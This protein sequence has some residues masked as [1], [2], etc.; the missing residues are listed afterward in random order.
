MTLTITGGDQ[1]YTLASEGMP[2]GSAAAVAGSTI[3]VT[4]TTPP[5]A[6]TKVVLKVSGGGKAG[7]RTV[8][9]KTT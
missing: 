3:T 7:R 1:P 2:S 4:V 9:V 5:A 8:T 6:D